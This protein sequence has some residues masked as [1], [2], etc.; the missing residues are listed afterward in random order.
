VLTR[1]RLDLLT[2]L[3]DFEVGLELLLSHV[4]LVNLIMLNLNSFLIR[5]ALSSHTL[6]HRLLHLLHGLGSILLLLRRLICLCDHP[7][8]RAHYSSVV[9]LLLA[10]VNRCFELLLVLLL[11]IELLLKQLF[12]L[13]L[14]HVAQLLGRQRLG[15]NLRRSLIGWLLLLL[16]LHFLE[17]LLL[18]KLVLCLVELELTRRLMLMHRLLWVLGVLRHLDEI[19]GG[20]WNRIRMDRLCFVYAALVWCLCG[21][22]LVELHIVTAVGLARFTT[23]CLCMPVP[24][25]SSLGLMDLL[26]FTKNG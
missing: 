5:L 25:Q 19:V 8:R 10:E 3:L 17:I 4:L 9:Y 1:R 23:S 21:E 11:S 13:L 16:L 15:N 12:L 7:D 20:F 24:A 22:L 14:R 2:W 6:I 18:S 26:V